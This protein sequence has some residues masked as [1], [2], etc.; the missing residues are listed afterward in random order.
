M[1]MIDSW[2]VDDRFQAN[3]TNKKRDDMIFVNIDH[4][5]KDSDANLNSSSIVNCFRIISCTSGVASIPT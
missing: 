2:V 1:E 5:L 3:T 4:K